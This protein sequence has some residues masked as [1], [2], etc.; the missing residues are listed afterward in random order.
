[1][2]S[3]LLR[4]SSIINRF[5]DHINHM[6]HDFFECIYD[7]LEKPEVQSLQYFTQHKKSSR[8]EHCLN[9]SYYSYRI[10]KKFNLD[11]RSTARGALLHDLYFYDSENFPQ[12]KIEK[13]LRNHP[14][15][16]LANAEK[17]CELNNIER[18]I[19][20]K[21]MW[22]ITVAPP[23]YRESMVVTFVDKYCAVLEACGYQMAKG[24]ISRTMVA[25][26]ALYVKLYD[27]S[28]S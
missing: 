25:S 16:A 9:V 11:Y 7:L 26:F 17:I 14:K 18:D 22:L 3:N 23:K 28:F 19:I 8:L 15:I 24:S 21:H 2:I 1:M 6:D 10:A 13:H 27:R 4:K 12:D 20:V 5:G